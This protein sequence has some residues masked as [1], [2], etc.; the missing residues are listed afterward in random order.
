MLSPWSSSASAPRPRS[1]PPAAEC[2]TTTGGG[3]PRLELVLDDVGHRLDDV[4]IDARGLV[5]DAGGDGQQ[6]AVLDA[7]DQQPRVVGEAATVL[8]DQ[9]VA[10]VHGAGVEDADAACQLGDEL[11]DRHRAGKDEV[12]A[13]RTRRNGDADETGS[14]GRRLAHGVVPRVLRGSA[15]RIGSRL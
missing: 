14:D 9:P 5:V 13:T 2:G 3:L 7:L 1:R 11:G 10:A 8:G 15:I 12:D 4:V 6:A